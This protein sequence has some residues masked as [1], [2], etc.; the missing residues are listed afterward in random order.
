[1]KQ[2]SFS[3]TAHASAGSSPHKSVL[4]AV[5]Q[6]HAG[7]LVMG[8]YGKPSWREFFFGTVTKHILAHSAVPLFLYH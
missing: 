3:A 1:L 7:M 6:H 8:A 4:E 5:Q 2:H